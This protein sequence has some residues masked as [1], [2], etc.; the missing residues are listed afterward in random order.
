MLLEDDTR[1]TIDQRTSVPWAVAFA[2]EPKQ[3][4]EVRV[5]IDLVYS[6]CSSFYTGSIRSEFREWTPG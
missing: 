2:P 5:Y 4:A 3:S 6:T 1:T